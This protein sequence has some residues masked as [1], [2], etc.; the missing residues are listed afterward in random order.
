MHELAVSQSIANLPASAVTVSASLTT[1]KH[2]RANALGNR[3]L[4]F[5]RLAHKQDPTR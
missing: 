2:H 4:S 3:E 5:R 1:Q